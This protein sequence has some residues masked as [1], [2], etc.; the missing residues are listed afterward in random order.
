VVGVHWRYIGIEVPKTAFEE[1]MYALEKMNLKQEGD[2]DMDNR[3]HKENKIMTHDMMY[4]SGM[5]EK[6]RDHS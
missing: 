2:R 5:D 1:R 6:A 3:I 4:P